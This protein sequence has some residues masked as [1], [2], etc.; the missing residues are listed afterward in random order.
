MLIHDAVRRAVVRVVDRHLAEISA[1]S[2]PPGVVQPREYYANHANRV[3][4][5]LCLVWPDSRLAFL[6]PA[7]D[8]LVAEEEGT[9]ASVVGSP[10]AVV[11][12]AHVITETLVVSWATVVKP[13][14]VF[15]AVG[16]KP[17][18]PTVMRVLN[19]FHMFGPDLHEVS[20]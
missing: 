4:D 1:P 15:A 6:S 2:H 8:K 11:E 5:D 18:V 3:V 7:P 17:L 20:A 14:V 10:I 19:L 9:T 16:A 12:A 13:A